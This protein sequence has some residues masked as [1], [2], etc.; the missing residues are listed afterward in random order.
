M[1]HVSSRSGV[2]TL[3]T[4]IH[5]LLTHLL[6]YYSW[7]AA[8]AAAVRRY[9]LPAPRLRQAAD[10]DRRDRQTDRH[11]TVTYRPCSAPRA[12]YKILSTDATD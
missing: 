6:T 4:A 10:V 12:L 8:R 11:R 7:Y 1:W 2:A 5:L 9:L 3:Q